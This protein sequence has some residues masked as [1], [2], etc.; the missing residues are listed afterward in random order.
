M[1]SY[2]SN[3]KKVLYLFGDEISPVAFQNL[4]KYVPLMDEIADE[5]SAYIEY[6]ISDFERPDSL[7]HRLYGNSEY[8]WTFFLMNANIRERGWPLSKQ[9]LLNA[10]TKIFYPDWTVSLGLETADSAALFANSYA[11]GSTVKLGNYDMIVKSKNLQIGT[12]T[13]QSPNY[14]A[15]YD[16]DF[17]TQGVLKESSTDINIKMVTVK[18]EI[19]GTRHYVNDSDNEIDFWFTSEIPISVSNLEWLEQENEQL[20]KIRVIRKDTI[21]NVVGQFK[22][23]TGL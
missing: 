1:S 13:L 8:D 12:I 5:I 3:F 6:E 2:F 22:S 9:D 14:S 4:S 21:E 10:A 17:T 16:S 23:L 20:K 15:S 19:F 11:A 7:S 18:K